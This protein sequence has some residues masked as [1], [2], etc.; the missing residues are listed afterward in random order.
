MALLM[1]NIKSH[2]V[3]TI[4]LGKGEELEAIL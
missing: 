4:V 2:H 3:D 1:V